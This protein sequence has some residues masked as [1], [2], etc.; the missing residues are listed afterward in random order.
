MKQQ[1]VK[2]KKHPLQIVLIVLASIVLFVLVLLLGI[3]GG[4]KL[5][6]IS[7]Y[8][9]SSAQFKIPGL[10]QGLEYV[11]DNDLFLTCGYAA[12]SGD[13]SAVYVVRADGTT[14]HTDLVNAD[15]TNYTG[16]T[17]GIARYGDYVYITAETGC[18]V[19]SYSDILNGKTQTQVLGSVSSIND[20]AYCNIYDGKFYVGAFYREQNYKTP[21]SH[22]L[23]TPCGDENK[24]LIAVYDIDESSP[25]CISQQ[26]DYVYSTIGL[27]QGMTF[28]EDEIVLS[29]SYGFATSHLYFYDTSKITQNTVEID[30]TLITVKYLDSDSQSAVVA[31]PPMSEEIVYKDGLIYIM[32]ES[33]S[34]KYIFGK[35]MS[36]YNCYA[37]D[38][39]KILGR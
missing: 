25:F 2:K 5:V 24:A 14:S 23:T 20:P 32:T 38:V 30:G 37:M 27:V 8:S 9:N 6:Y 3:K 28:T 4:E 11:E 16:H 34:N 1:K 15:G 21:E 35:F 31:A 36:G 29:T 33:A 17:G 10:S 7:F 19:F 18:D 22:H 39:K 12:K 26:L 13:A